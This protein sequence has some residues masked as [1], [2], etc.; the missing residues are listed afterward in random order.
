MAAT[1]SSN[2]LMWEA[3][4]Q[5]GRQTDLLFHVEQTVM[6]AV[7]AD[8][9]CLDAGLYLGGQDRVVVIA[10]F[11]GVPPRLPDPPDE[12]LLRS[13]HQW[14]FRRHATCPGPAARTTDASTSG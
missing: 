13:V 6:P 11:T 14:P 12:L 10:H 7:L 4:A 9:T 8:P 1:A 2:T 5:A 3:R